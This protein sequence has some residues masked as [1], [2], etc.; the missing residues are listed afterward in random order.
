MGDFVKG[1]LDSGDRSELSAALML[2]RRIDSFTDAH[3]IVVGSRGRVSA[4]RRRFA[5]VLVDMFYDHFLA[6][7]WSDY[8]DEPLDRF[9]ARVYR[10]L[11]S[12]SERLPE[13]LRYIAPHMARTDWLGS[14]RDIDAVGEA[15]DRI[16][17]RLKRGNHLLGSVEELVANYAALEQ[18]FREFFPEVVRF[19]MGNEGMR[20]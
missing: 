11:L 15:L 10:V 8:S 4:A 7:N 14:Y 12:N 3:P 2:H 16:G 19:A 18:D 20:E 17:N 1:R 6:R 5:G 13:R 9:T